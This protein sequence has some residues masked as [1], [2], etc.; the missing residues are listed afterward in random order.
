MRPRQQYV[1]FFVMGAVLLI[2]VGGIL[3]RQRLF[4]RD[5][6]WEHVQR[7]HTWRVGMDPSFPPFEM[8]TQ[9]GRVVGFDVDLA[10]AIAREWGVHVDIVTLG[11]DG[12]IDAVRTHKIDAAISAIPY[13]PLL[14][15]DVRYSDPYF[16]AGWRLVVLRTSSIHTL[17]DVSGIRLAVEWGS[18]GDVWAR[19]L[20]RTHK[21]V[22]L[23]LRPT[24]EEAL[25]ALL[26]GEADAAI[27]DGLTARMR[28][29]I[30]VVGDPFYPDPYV[31]VMPLEAYRLQA[32]VNKSLT[33]LRRRGD[34]ADLEAKWLQPR[35]LKTDN[36]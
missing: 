28:Q 36:E 8:L 34:L 35:A 10:Q 32:E 33:T 14:T 6:V 5:P 17:E 7:T 22:T 15:K 12:L 19:R 24:T 21:N 31:I 3:L 9:D 20:Q 13:D 18:E 23:V 30:R 26:N 27:V 4:A 1:I 11:F 25:Q 16:D 2:G 29:D